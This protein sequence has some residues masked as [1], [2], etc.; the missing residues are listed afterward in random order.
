MQAIPKHA[1]STPLPGA[2]APIAA[3]PAS[4]AQHITHLVVAPRSHCRSSQ[5]RGAAGRVVASRGA[6]AVGDS[7]RGGHPIRPPYR[8][9][10]AAPP[11]RR[12]RLD[13]ATPLPGDDAA[14]PAYNV[15]ERGVGWPRLGG[16]TLPSARTTRHQSGSAVNR[17]VA[18]S[19][20]A[21]SER[22]RFRLSCRRAS[23]ANRRSRA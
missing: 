20:A 5:A 21:M 14:N 17:S 16:R 2:A 1:R 7:P 11:R 22:A 15:N 8:R 6:G 9:S 18:P 12:G 19:G 3:P 4:M 23:V 10:F 13:V